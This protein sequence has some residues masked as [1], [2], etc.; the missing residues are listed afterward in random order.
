M[1]DTLDPEVISQDLCL[2][3]SRHWKKNDP[4]DTWKGNASASS[5]GWFLYSYEIECEELDDHFTWLLT[6]IVPLASKLKALMVAGIGV[7]ICCNM[8]GKNPI[9]MVLSPIVISEVSKLGVEL[10]FTIEL[11]SET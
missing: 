4:I 1:H 6:R 9:S 2:V 11:T 8:S 10:D 5:G 3:P 7:D